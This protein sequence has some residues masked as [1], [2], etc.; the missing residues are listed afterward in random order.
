MALLSPIWLVAVLPWIAVMLWLFRGRRPRVP[1]PYLPLWHGPAPV[2]HPRRKLQTIPFAA[3]MALLAALLA[4]L[5][6]ARPEVRGLGP[7]DGSRL[8]LVV[9]R[10]MSM[11]ARTAGGP[12][13]EERTRA[14]LAEI[15]RRDPS[16]AIDLVPIPGDG[17]IQT[18][19]AECLA[20][21]AAWSPTARDTRRSVEEVVGAHLAA[22]NTTVF[23]VTD[24]G[25]PARDRL[26]RI[27]RDTRVSDVGIAAVAARDQPT[28]QVMV[29]VLNQSQLSHGMV[30]VS[31]D[32]G[33]IRQS[34]DLPSPGETRDYF[35]TAQR[36]GTVISVRLIGQDDLTADDQAWLVREG[37]SP[38]VEVRAQVSPELERLIGAYSRARPAAGDST[39][40]PLVGSA[41][42]LPA[43][44]PAVVID[45]AERERS[46]GTVQV[47]A[48]PVTAHVSFEGLAMRVGGEPPARW[49]PLVRVGS[50]I[51]VAVR[52]DG[53][54]QVWVGFDAPGWPTEPDYVVFWTNVFDWAGGT[55]AGATFAAHPLDEWSPEWKPVEPAGMVP[56]DVPELYR[57]ADGTLR[58]F[59]A[60]AVAFEPPMGGDD[61]RARASALTSGRSPLGLSLVLLALAA[62]A[63]AVA[64]A[65]WKRAARPSRLPE[66][67]APARAPGAA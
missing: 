52:P 40:V 43:E 56:G 15:A 51:A 32:Q 37:S 41:A 59:N 33:P 17:V 42:E 61:W 57:R 31:T 65:T 64:A 36:L 63:L 14:L 23:A 48:H 1:V 22:S 46:P 6:A 8:V 27:G 11:S 55:G 19:A 2:P 29:R 60:P 39:R 18:T 38:R 58:S 21:V 53:P 66:L 50:R 54:R 4:I 5:A 44:G 30:E 47:V 24:H 35:V 10:G 34:I 45:A 16:Q 49:A 26:V 28:P 7:R 3:A 20:R 13:F 62:A 67:A 12:R 25:L 9:D